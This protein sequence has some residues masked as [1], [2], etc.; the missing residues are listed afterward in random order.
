MRVEKVFLKAVAS[1][2]WIFEQRPADARLLHL[3]R[4]ELELLGLA[5][6]IKSEDEA[7]Q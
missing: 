1:L 6:P 7:K 2:D 4:G 3:T 5:E